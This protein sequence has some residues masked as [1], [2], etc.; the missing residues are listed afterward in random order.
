MLERMRNSRGGYI[1]LLYGPKWFMKTYTF[2]TPKQA[3]NMSS[4]YSERWPVM[5]TLARNIIINDFRR[6]HASHKVRP[7]ARNIRPSEAVAALQH[8]SSP[9]PTDIKIHYGVCR[10]CCPRQGATR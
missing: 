2:L 9:R 5:S 10:K 3:A 6:N 4:D 1:S 7:K 8:S